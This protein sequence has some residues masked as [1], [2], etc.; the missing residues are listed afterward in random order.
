MWVVGTVLVSADEASLF[1]CMSS[2]K[3]WMQK[4]TLL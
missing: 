1:T 2:D 3:D 4:L